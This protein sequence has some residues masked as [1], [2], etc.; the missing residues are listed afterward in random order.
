MKIRPL[1][2]IAAAGAFLPLIS[3]AE[4]VP[5]AEDGL[6]LPAIVIS[7][8]KIPEQRPLR[9]VTYI[10]SGAFDDTA[11]SAI[12]DMASGLHSL[13]VRRRSP[14][15][16]QADLNIR[17]ATFEQSA[18]LINGLRMNDPQTAHHN[19]DIPF[20]A[21]DLERLELLHGGGS[22][23]YGP[24]AF[25]GAL[26]IITKRPR[27]RHVRAEFGFGR[28]DYMRE[29]VSITQ[30][31][32]PV[33]NRV[34]FERSRSSGHTEA[35]DFEITT[36]SFDSLLEGESGEL[37]IIGGYS[38]KDFGASTF[39]SSLYPKEGEY[40][41]TRTL[42]ARGRFAKDAISVEPKFYYRRHWDRFILDR[43]RRFWMRNTHK[44]YTSG[45]EVQLTVETGAGAVI[46]GADISRDKI[47]STNLRKHERNRWAM[48]AGY[49]YGMPCGFAMNADLRADR[50]SG[51]GWE[52][53]PS[54]ELGYELNDRTRL[55]SSVNRSYRIPSFTDLYYVSPANIGNERLKAE[56]AW[57]YE[58][59]FDYEGDFFKASATLFK[60]HARDVIDWTRDDAAEAWTAENRGGIETFGA[61]TL[62]KL[63][64]AEF[65]GGLFS[66]GVSAGYDFIHSE[67][68]SSGRRFS[69][70]ALDYLKHNLHVKADSRMPLGIKGMVKF[71][72]RERA[73]G[74]PYFLLDAGACKEARIAGFEVEIYAE[75]VNLFN[76]SYSEISGVPMP[77][78]GL[79]GGARAGF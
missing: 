58:G 72:F 42:I 79:F 32:G 39:Y 10:T 71:S 57:S 60:R 64:A 40:T 41:D 56:R 18:V 20:T 68:D 54:L 48:L 15:G 74:Q 29:A 27:G 62:F 78:L 3:P 7:S 67:K 28:D 59:G 22:A 36:F 14:C 23:L 25:G 30:P 12:T 65:C 44:T 43:D 69:K 53:S 19:T 26:N 76:T 75:A 16:V 1:F 63:R 13:D 11:G 34:S 55:R 66:C 8:S 51:F 50:F 46:L 21:M 73:G 4:E 49:N 31:T 47:D 9:N 6:L 38:Y 52:L 61:E 17:G 37:E 70:Y 5:A 24:D 2:F 35:S 33:G 77:G 45:A